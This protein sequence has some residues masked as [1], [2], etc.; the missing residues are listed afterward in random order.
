MSQAYILKE[1][2]TSQS[3]HTSDVYQYKKKI[4]HVK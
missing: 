1:N 4:M 3:I 2:M